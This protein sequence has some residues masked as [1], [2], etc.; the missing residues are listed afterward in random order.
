MWDVSHRGIIV[1]TVV[2]IMLLATV[3]AAAVAWHGR[4]RWY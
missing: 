1:T 2:T 4:G 3:T